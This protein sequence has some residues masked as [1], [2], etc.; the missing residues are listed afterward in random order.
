MI[1]HNFNLLSSEIDAVYHFVAAKLG[2]S[3][4]AMN[5]LY[6][7]CDN[8][9]ECLMNDFLRRTGMSK[10]TVNSSVSKLEA[11]GIVSISMADKKR[12]RAELTEKGKE[13]AGRTVMRII[14]KENE[15]FSSWTKEE[16][17][18]YLDLTRRYLE[19]FREKTKDIKK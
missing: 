1:L 11:E 18:V 9:G 6:V 13:Y 8:G 14:E 5:I 15:I 7:L 12:K 10:Q 16:Q 2:M 17:T 19:E 4:S 3:D